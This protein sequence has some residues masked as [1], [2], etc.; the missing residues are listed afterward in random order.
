MRRLDGVTPLEEVMDALTALVQAGKVLY[1]GGST[2]P[3]WRFAQ[4]IALAEHKGCARPVAMQNLY[5]LLQREEEREMIPLCLEAG[6]GLIPY[7]PLARGGLAGPPKT[8]RAP[9]D[10]QATPDDPFRHSDQPIPRK[11]PDIPAAPT[12]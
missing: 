11:L 6:V 3:A 8:E 9:E 7:S 5:N 4:M 2:M 10:K 12:P 1:I